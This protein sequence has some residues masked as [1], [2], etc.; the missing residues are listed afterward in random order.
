[1]RLEAATQEPSKCVQTSMN[2]RHESQVPSTV[3]EVHTH[4]DIHRCEQC[5][6]TTSNTGGDKTQLGTTTSAESQRRSTP[7]HDQL[8]AEAY[9]AEMTE[10]LSLSSENVALYT[11]VTQ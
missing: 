2:P 4:E 10:R 8:E 11:E 9:V 1:M 5:E 6:A 3:I 7:Q